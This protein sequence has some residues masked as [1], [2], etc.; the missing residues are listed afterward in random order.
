MPFIQ[1]QIRRDTA[2][3][4]T[5]S[6]PIL[7]SG[8]IGINLDTYQYKIGNGTQGWNLLPYA[9]IVGPTGSAGASIASGT[10][11]TGPVGFRGITGSTGPT[12]IGAQGHTGPTRTGNT[13]MTGATGI[14]V[15]GPTGSIGSIGPTGVTGNTGIGF[16]GSTGPTGIG[17]TGPTGSSSSITGPTGIS[18]TG[19]TG[20]TGLTGSTIRNGYITA[21]IVTTAS[22]YLNT[23]VQTN[24]PSSI[25]TWAIQAGTISSLILTFNNT[26]YNNQYIP[27]NI[28]GMLT[29]FNPTLVVYAS[30]MISLGIY[31]GT[32]N[33]TTTTLQWSSGLS[34]WQLYFNVNGSSFG[35]TYNSLNLYLNVF[36]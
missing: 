15:T 19:S 6:N 9:G 25:G 2:T 1:L 34:S 12:G 35:S 30:Q 33:I 3:N 32:T 24:F 21:N 17:F 22:N 8:E 4:W 11:S 31:S 27:P 20:P 5:T 29:V 16:T 7:A 28:S 26:N 36:N 23:L 18:G 13:G 14:G 10:G